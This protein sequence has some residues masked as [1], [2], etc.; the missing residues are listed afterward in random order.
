MGKATIIKRRNG[1]VIR[2][3]KRLGDVH[4]RMETGQH[5]RIHATAFVGGS[6]TNLPQTDDK[7]VVSYFNGVPKTARLG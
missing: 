2:Y 6:T 4:I 5:I 7:V 1:T 3:D